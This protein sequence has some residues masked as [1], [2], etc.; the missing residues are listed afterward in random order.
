MR[1]VL[2]D[3]L[4]RLPERYR[5]PVL[6]CYLESKTTEEAARQLGCPRGTVLSRLATARERL[7][8]RLARRGLTL[9]AMALASLVAENAAHA[10][11]PPALVD[12]T[13]KSAAAFAG[14]TAAS[15]SVAPHIAALAEGVV[16]AM[17]FTR[18]KTAAAVICILGLLGLGAFFLPWAAW[19]APAPLVAAPASEAAVLPP[20]APLQAKP[21]SDKELLQGVWLVVSGKKDGKD[22][23]AQFADS[24]KITFDGDRM[25]A[26]LSDGNRTDRD[27]FAFEL[28][29]SARPKHLTFTKPTSGNTWAGIYKLEGNRLTI[30][31]P[32][33]LPSAERPKDFDSKPGSRTLLLVLKREKPAKE[34][35]APPRPAPSPKNTEKPKDDHERIL[36][37]W[38]VVSRT[39]AGKKAPKR[40]MRFFITKN[41]IAFEDDTGVQYLDRDVLRYRLDPSQ[42][43]KAIDLDRADRDG[44]THY[45]IYRFEGDQ[46]TI[47]VSDDE[48]TERPSTFASKEGSR[49]S[50]VVLKR[51][52]KQQPVDEEKIKGIADDSRN[53]RHNIRSMM[54][55]Y[56][57]MSA[58]ER[59]HGRLPAAAISNKDGKPL[60]SWRVAILPYIN[61]DALYRQFKL[62]EP[63]DSEHNLKLLPKI[64]EIITTMGAKTKEDYVTAYRVF[65]GPDTAFDGKEGLKLEDLT[66]GRD[67]TLLLVEAAEAVPWTKPEEL[68]YDATKPLPKL[69]GALREQFPIIT[70]N[71]AGHYLPLRFNHDL[72]RALITRND[73]KAVTIDDLQK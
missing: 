37:T 15:G 47:C 28:D 29:P 40:D 73:G 42:N 2:D 60:L 3:E 46:L 55:L 8:R 69:G 45:G 68:P 14:G 71:G 10:G 21:R 57:G 20:P 54:K 41:Y 7:R 64:P 25:V 49:I 16:H 1:G 62:D 67:T 24:S 72:F 18:L 51:S 35:P 50:L 61:H 56:Q 66:D 63:W 58:Y 31:S 48:Q 22:L 4:N 65:T 34:P 44:E 30:C 33:G 13:M 39:M 27:E 12:A 36:G 52:A 59:E 6:L 19:A 32:G 5:V 17:L 26:V 53:R 38:D 43:P 9:S 70:A 11:L 23:P